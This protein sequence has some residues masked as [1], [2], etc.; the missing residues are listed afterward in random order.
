MK[1]TI[2]YMSYFV[3]AYKVKPDE[4]TNLQNIKIV[5]ENGKSIGIQWYQEVQDILVRAEQSKVQQAAVNQLNVLHDKLNKR[6]A[7]LE[8]LNQK[9]KGFFINMEIE[10]VQN[11]IKKI[12]QEISRLEETTRATT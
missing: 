10:D 1:Y 12:S 11:E 8:K 7:E 5:S 9:K 2:E 3:L 4:P 6:Q